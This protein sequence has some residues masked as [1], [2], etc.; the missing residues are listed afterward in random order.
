MYLVLKLVHI[1]SATLAVGAS[2]TYGVWALRGA[3]DGAHE[4]FA[5]RGLLW[6]DSWLVN[7]AFT[8][9]GLSGAAL[10]RLGGLPWGLLWVRA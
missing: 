5:L 8:V 1:L 10:V 3:R 9:A 6:L 2:L 4:G 7:P